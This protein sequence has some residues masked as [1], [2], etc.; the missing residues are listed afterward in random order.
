MRSGVVVASVAALHVRRALVGE[1]DVTLVS[2]AKVGAGATS[3]TH[4]PSLSVVPGPHVIPLA[5]ST[6][7]A[8][9]I[10]PCCVVPGPQIDPTLL[11]VVH[12][13][14]TTKTAGTK[15]SVVDLSVMTNSSSGRRTRLISSNRGAARALGSTWR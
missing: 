14:R 3:T 4:A 13:E 12:D 5:A 11:F 2:P 9:Q 15:M 8:T 1:S 6:S 10:V 7:A